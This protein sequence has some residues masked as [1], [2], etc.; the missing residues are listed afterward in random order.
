[1]KRF[2]ALMLAVIT[3]LATLTACSGGGDDP[4]ATTTGETTAE[5]TVASTTEPKLYVGYGR[6]NITPRDEK[7]KVM[8]LRLAGYPETRIANSILTDLYASCVAVRDAEGDTVLLY[9]VDHLHLHEEFIEKVQSAIKKDLKID[10]KNVI[11]TSSHTHAAPD[12]A[13]PYST[14]ELV[15]DYT[16]NILCTGILEA[17]R[18][19]ITDLA[20]CTDLYAGTLDATGYNF[21]RRYVTDKQGG[22]QHEIDGDHTMPVVKF[23]RDGKKDVIITNWSA[24]A[25]TV[26]THNRTAVSGDYYYYFTELAESELNAHA[27]I[28][29]GNSGDVNPFSKIETENTVK[30]TR[31][32]GRNLA[33]VLIDNISSLKKIEIISDVE[34][35]TKTITVNY[36]HSRD[37]KISQATEIVNL[38]NSE[39]D[40]A[41]Y[42][43]KCIAYG[44]SDI[45]EAN[46]IYW[47]YYQ[48]KNITMKVSAVTIGNLAF[49]TAPYEML[50]KTGMDIKDRS[51]FEVTFACGYTNGSHGYI[52]PEYAFVNSGYEVTSCLYEKGTA[53]KIQ[54]EISTLIDKFYANTYEK[55]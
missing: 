18:A 51:K 42:R 20:L 52:P 23:L 33:N 22:L 4:A 26:I 53:E 39:G 21:I 55:Q 31:A 14:E 7:G 11:I 50:T 44:I 35:L 2:F 28:F 10:A 40:T 27:S 5:I 6:A 48:P 47:I 30:T 1:M 29:N 3:L 19:A 13:Y 37:A 15:I 24:H 41:T 46:R 36:D 32:Y 12:I 38:Y 8:P 45:N 34:A 17:G 16:D 9:T 43:S 54:Q 49:G 25:D